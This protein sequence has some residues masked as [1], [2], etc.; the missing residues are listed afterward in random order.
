MKPT[1]PIQQAIPSWEAALGKDVMD[2]TKNLANE[3]NDFRKLANLPVVV[4]II[5]ELNT[6]IYLQE[7]ALVIE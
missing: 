1:S 2:R 5:T 3:M 7:I 6:K 4:S